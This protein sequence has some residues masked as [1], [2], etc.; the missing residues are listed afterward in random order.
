MSCWLCND[1]GDLGGCDSCGKRSG[2]HK[3]GGGVKDPRDDHGA[4]LIMIAELNRKVADL[5]VENKDLKSRYEDAVKKYCALR[6][7]RNE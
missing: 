6:R 7:E 1:L 2:A 3:P 5:E 4:A